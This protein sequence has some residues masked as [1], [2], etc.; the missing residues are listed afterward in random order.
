MLPLKEAAFALVADTGKGKE[1]TIRHYK[2]GNQVPKVTDYDCSLPSPLAGTPAA[3]PDHLILSLSNG[4]LVRKQ[5]DNNAPV[6]GL[7]WRAERTDEN[8]PS[9]VVALNETGSD[10][11]VTDGSRGLKRMTW[12]KGGQMCQQKANLDLPARIVAA[13][14]VVFTNAGEFQVFVADADNQVNILQGS[15]TG[16]T[17]ETTGQRV[18]MAGGITGGPFVLGD[19]VGCV[20]ARRNL[21]VLAKGGEKG[22]SFKAGAPI[23]GR[24]VLIGKSVI[25]GDLEGRFVALDPVNGKR[26]SE[27]YKLKTTAAPTAS[28]VPFG[29]DRLFLPLT[30]GTVMFLSLKRLEAEAK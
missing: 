6:Q 1:L 28:P 17:L 13:P 21:V 15:L 14:L 2:V 11:L 12:P 7:S 24:P 3:W 25:V 22:W 16:N 23:V 27:G 19:Q 29:N 10:F 20:V 4:Y 26:K 5:L 9:Y 30:D 8:A 18:P